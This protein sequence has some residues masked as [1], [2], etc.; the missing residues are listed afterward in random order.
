[1]NTNTEIL[2]YDSAAAELEQIVADL[3]NEVVGIDDLA[4]K[5]ERAQ[6]LIRFCREKLRE[7]D[8]RLQDM[9]T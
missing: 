2:T 7:V 1:M 8:E 6:E 9:I 3:Q 5:A 4:A